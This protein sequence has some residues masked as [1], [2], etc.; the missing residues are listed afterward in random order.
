MTA[1]MYR[2]GQKAPISGIYEVVNELG[3]PVGQTR[4]INAGHVFPPVP[5]PGEQYRLKQEVKPIF[6]SVASKAVIDETT[7]TFAVVIKRLADK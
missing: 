2:P 7:S 4:P 5:N 3:T 6:T 1:I